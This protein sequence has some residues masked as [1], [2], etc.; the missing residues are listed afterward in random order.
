MAI[1]LIHC[2][3]SIID[4][5]GWHPVTIFERIPTDALEA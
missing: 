3:N 1:I 4:F 5:G 2:D